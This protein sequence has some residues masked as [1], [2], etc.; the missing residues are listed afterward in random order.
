MKK[1]DKN[2]S[3]PIQST[4]SS[5]APIQNGDSFSNQAEQAESITQARVMAVFQELGY[6]DLGNWQDRPGNS[7]IEE[8]YLRAFLTRQEI[9]EHWQ[10]KAIREL[11][12]AADLPQSLYD[13]NQAVYEK[14]RYGAKV[15]PDASEKNKTVGLIDWQ[16]PEQNH[17]AV[18]QEVSVR[19][20]RDKRRTKRPDI[21]LYVNGIALAILELKKSDVGLSK[22]IRQHLYNQ[23]DEFIGH[24]FSTMQ[25]VMVG[26]DSQG[27]R[28]GTIETNEQFFSAWKEPDNGI[29]PISGN[30]LDRHLRQLCSKAR[31]LELIHDFIVFDVGIKKLCRHN[32][33]FGVKAAQ[34]FVRRRE[35]GIIWHTQGSGKSLTMLWLA[36]WLLENMENAR[37]LIITDRIELDEQIQRIFLGVQEKIYRTKSNAD[38]VQV[39]NQSTPF[40]ICSLIHKFKARKEKQDRENQAKQDQPNQANQ[41]QTDQ[42][43]ENR[44]EATHQDR[45]ETAQGDLQEIRQAL[46][47]DFV[48]K[49]NLF[50]FVDECH[51]TQA[52]DGDKNSERDEAGECHKGGEF[53]KAMKAI[54]PN[55]LFIGFTGTPILKADKIRTHELFG[56]YIHIYKF[57]EAVQ[58]G[59][60]VDLCYEAREI[61]EETLTSEKIDHWFEEKTRGMSELAKAQLKRRWITI[62]QVESAFPRL[63]RIVDEIVEDMQHEPILASG[64]G[65]AMLVASSIYDACRFYELFSRTI[66]AGKCAVITSYRPCQDD[67]KGEE[68]GKGQTMKQVQYE[69]ITRMV[70]DWFA[71]QTKGNTDQQKA[72]NG[73]ARKKPKNGADNS[74][75]RN[76]ADRKELEDGTAHQK[77]KNNAAREEPEDYIAKTDL[78]EQ[79]ARQKF[80]TQPG[81]MRL[82][83]VVDKLLTGFD[84]PP[85]TYLYIDKTMQDHGL[86]QA[87]CRVNRLCGEEKKYGYI[88]DYRQLCENLTKAVHDYTTSADHALAGY[89]PE[90]VQGLLQD[91]KTKARGRLETAREAVKYLCEKVVEA[92]PR[93]DSRGKPANYTHDHLGDYTH[94]HTSDYDNGRADRHDAVHDGWPALEAYLRYFGATEAGNIQQLQA[95]EPKRVAFYQA[96]KELFRAYENAERHLAKLDYSVEESKIIAREVKH[97]KTVYHAIQLHSGDVV[98]LKQYEPDMLKMMDTYIT[99]DPSQKIADLDGF[100]L[101]Q[102]LAQHGEKIMEDLPEAI[103]KNPIAMTETIENNVRRIIIEQHPINPKY[104]ESMSALLDALILEQ[105]QKQLEYRQYLA[106]LMALAKKVVSPTSGKKY[107]TSLDTPRKR[108]FFDNL[109]EDEDLAIRV[110]TQI[111]RVKK[112][113]WTSNVVKER[114]VQYAIEDVIPDKVLAQNILELAKKYEH[115]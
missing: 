45:E 26:N 11:R 72:K 23:Q 69:V 22:A 113:G 57:N 25:L 36:K 86:F 111:N 28:Y 96:A 32:Q 4:G 21:V 94:D 41:D 27:I 9:P 39:L 101:V 60:V 55:A 17:F 95:N 81:E 51:R 24:F 108:A 68:T 20:F 106:K 49:G 13:R 64:K 102:L 1:P 103:R 44:E 110:D 74:K 42:S 5:F 80:I 46:P 66:L 105:R 73:N 112:D 29:S 98:D 31:F 82:L 115:G 87:I 59:M 2:S 90:D 83:I 12:Q 70:N 109:G 97:F 62:Q 88:I 85:A 56:R 75:P 52:G 6:E 18:A 40:V 14:L 54:L 100:T 34:D 3:A 37:I 7:N 71:H 58:D 63:Q 92:Y 16:H 93:Q 48:A 65:N 47:L 77:N 30:L 10:D 61:R 38:L 99:A 114:E 89:D 19:C 15:Q 79:E 78:F 43:H 104:Y 84:A 91:W 50:V 67:L 8:T 35:G 107:P 33:Y 53:H 76:G